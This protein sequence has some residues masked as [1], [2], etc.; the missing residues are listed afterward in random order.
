MD[1]ENHPS[2][3]Y[4]PRM[5]ATNSDARRRVTFPPDMAPRSPV[6]IDTVRPGVEWRVVV[7][8]ASPAKAY[9]RGRIVKGRNGVLCW[10]GDVGEDPGEALVANR[11]ADD[12][13]R[14]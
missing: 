3:G 5:N 9:S 6:L 8:E 13:A 7:P 1:L 12:R 11:A 14:E 4:Y 10:S 2:A